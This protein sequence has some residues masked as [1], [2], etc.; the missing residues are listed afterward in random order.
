MASPSPA[1][2]IVTLTS[3]VVV[4]LPFYI[5]GGGRGRGRGREKKWKAGEGGA[6]CAADPSSMVEVT[7]AGRRDLAL[8]N[9]CLLLLLSAYSYYICS[10]CLI[11]ALFLYIYE[12]WEEEE[13]WKHE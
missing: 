2:L 12:T 10:L 8:L 3:C 5:Y 7:T 11:A 4:C 9:A 1:M 6:G 13:D